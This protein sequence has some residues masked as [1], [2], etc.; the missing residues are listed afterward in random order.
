MRW[1]AKSAIQNVVSLLPEHLSLALY[2][3]MQRLCGGLRS[4][5]PSSRLVAGMN[6]WNRILATG[7]DLRGKTFLEVGT[8]RACCLSR[9]ICWAVTRPS[10]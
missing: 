2:Y 10:P 1:I 5:D 9:C 7:R 8:G 6:I 3:R 4:Y